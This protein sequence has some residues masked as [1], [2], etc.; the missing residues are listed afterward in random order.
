MSM[1]QERTLVR[2]RVIPQFDELW[3]VGARVLASLIDKVYRVG[4]QV[5]FPAIQVGS[6]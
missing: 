1:A 4:E 5:H 2:A 6:P 3:R